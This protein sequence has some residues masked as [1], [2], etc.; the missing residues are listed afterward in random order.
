MNLFRKMNTIRQGIA[1]KLIFLFSILVIIIILLMEI[2]NIFGIPFVENG[3][4]IGIEKKRI[5][6]SLNLIAD[7]KEARFE[8]WLEE[9]K[10][11]TI[12]LAQN[13]FTIKPLIKIH[14]D[15]HKLSNSGKRGAD[16][17]DLLRKNKYYSEYKRYLNEIIS[18]YG[19]YYS[20]WIADAKD[21]MV[22]ISSD[23]NI[24]GRNVSKFDFFYKALETDKVYMT[25]IIKDPQFGFTSLHFSKSLKDESGKVI[26]VLVM[27]VNPEEILTPILHTGDG[28]GMTGEALLVNEDVTIITSLKKPL[29]NGMIAEPLKY[30]INAEP[31]RLAA[32]GKEGIIESRDYR[33]EKV[34]AAYRYLRITD[35]IGWGMVVK[36]DISEL[37]LPM[38]KNIF[39]TIFIGIIAMCI[40]L[41]FVVYIS[42]KISRPIIELEEAAKKI[43][44]GNY[45]ARTKVKTADE[46]GSLGKSFNKMAVSLQQTIADREEIAE[47]LE[48]FAYSVSHDLRVPLRAISGFSDILLEEHKNDL[49]EEGKRLLNIVVKNTKKMDKLINDLLSFSRMGRKRIVYEKIDMN[50]LVDEAFED[51]RQLFPEQNIDFKKKDLGFAR[52]DASLIKQVFLNLFSNA[53]KFS[54]N[55]D[56]SVIE[57][58]REKREKRNIYYVKDNGIGFDPKYIN[59]LFNVF[60]RLHSP[61]EFEGTGIGL[62]NIKR[63]ITRHGGEVWAEG[64]PDKGATFYFSLSR[65]EE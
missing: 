8:R 4:L 46:I 54:K 43:G 30:R 52:G 41:I 45:D 55:K 15:F 47:N 64:K 42:R 48:S 16:F 5:K 21:K 10:D 28:L 31:A 33:G 61:E 9:R 27:T 14:N 58:G 11:D 26:A 6:K 38:K 49:N 2:V 60:Q 35:E 65:T 39:Y 59:K 29:E 24:L 18:S 13:P 56:V 62:A 17:W 12:V 50:R 23:E 19:V 1:S 25:D 22:F 63:I 20:I 51:V 3:G 7:L 32:S 36:T 40:A 57:V 34:M 53:V 44:E 37:F